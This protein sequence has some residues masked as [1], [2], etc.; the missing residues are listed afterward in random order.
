MADTVDA[1]VLSAAQAVP[2][3]TERKTRYKASYEGGKSLH[4]AEPRV[5]RYDA[6]FNAEECAHI[7][8]LA[9]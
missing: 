1:S 7:M 9:R 3:P 8:D 4:S 2:S 6:F 5:H